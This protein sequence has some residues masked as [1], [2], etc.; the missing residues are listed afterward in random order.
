MKHNLVA[1]AALSVL[2]ILTLSQHLAISRSR[3]I[4]IN[5]CMSINTSGY[6]VLDNNLSGVQPHKPYCIYI[7][8][9]NVILNGLNHLLKGGGKYGIFISGS[10]VTVEHLSID[11]YQYGIYIV[12]SGNRVKYVNVTANRFGLFISSSN[13]LVEHVYA[14]NDT[15]GLYIRG[16]MNSLYDITAINCGYGIEIYGSYDINVGYINVVDDIM[17]LYLINVSNGYVAFVNAHN[18]GVG[19]NITGGST[20][21]V[22]YVEAY[23]D[24]HI[25]VIQGR[26]VTVSGA[27]NI[28]FIEVGLPA[29]AEWSVNLSGALVSSMARSITFIMPPGIYNCIIQPIRGFN[30]ITNLSEP[31]VNATRNETIQVRFMGIVYVKSPAPFNANGTLEPRGIHQFYTPVNLGFP[32]IERLNN[33]SRLRFEYIK[34]YYMLNNTYIQLGIPENLTLTEPANVTAVYQLQYLIKIALPNGIIFSNWYND[35]SMIPLPQ[36]ITIDDERYV[37]ANNIIVVANE[38]TAAGGVLN[39]S[40]YYVKQVYVTILL[41]NGAIH[42]WFNY[43]YVVH[44]PSVIFT[45]INMYILFQGGSIIITKPGLV[46]VNSRYVSIYIIIAVIAVIILATIIALKRRRSEYYDVATM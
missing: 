45:G 21:N 44:L 27:V 24:A 20:I 17:G 26:N 12:N 29:N 43:G 11:N 22:S 9:S 40:K 35:G 6:Y 10:N 33:Y 3:G 14:T 37:L 46:N 16:P 18:D 31:Y 42:R 8:A 2:A 4:V 13:N 15:F 5:Q 34:V 36:N 7:S 23:N 19:L 30:T 1:V 38:T 28:T 25:F 32:S 41:P 39:L